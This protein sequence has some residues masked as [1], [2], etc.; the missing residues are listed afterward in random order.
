VSRNR[1]VGTS[2]GG[3][4]LRRLVSLCTLLCLVPL[5]FLTYFTIHLADRAVVREVNARL[6][7]T[8]AVTSVL[9]QQQMQAV[10]DL[11]AS[12]ASRRLLV[13]ALGDG[14][15]AHFRLDEIDRQLSDLFAAQAGTGGAFLTDTECRLTNVHPTTPEIV[16]VDFAFRDWCRGPVRTRRTA[17]RSR[18]SPPSTPSA[19]RSP[20]RFRPTRHLPACSGCVRRC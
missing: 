9:V 13:E 11:T 19:G 12:Y 4:P 1:I 20:Q 6:R 3:F 17:R 18:G 15:P 8:S 16:G 5:A 10:A 2:R 14:D 7:T